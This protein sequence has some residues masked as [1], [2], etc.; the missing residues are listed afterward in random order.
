VVVPGL[1]GAGNKDKEELQAV[2]IKTKLRQSADEMNT[3]L[4]AYYAKFYQDDKQLEEVVKK[5][6][7]RPE[8]FGKRNAD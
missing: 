1:P 7:F 5:K 8:S 2:D 4:E 3:A 6:R